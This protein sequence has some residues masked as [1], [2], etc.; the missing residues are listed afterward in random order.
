MLNW[1]AFSL[2]GKIQKYISKK[3]FIS[4]IYILK[5]SLYNSTYVYAHL[6]QIMSYAHLVIKQG[7]RLSKDIVLT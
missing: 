1:Y 5:L 2:R 3:D 4:K 6:Y 7:K